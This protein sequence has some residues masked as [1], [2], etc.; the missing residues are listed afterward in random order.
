MNG[1]GVPLAVSNPLSATV[2]Q[3]GEQIAL[4]A[5]WLHEAHELLTQA[6]VPEVLPNETA[7]VAAR[8]RCLLQAYR[9]QGIDQLPPGEMVYPE[10]FTPMPFAADDDFL[11]AT[12]SRLTPAWFR[13]AGAWLNDMALAA[14]CRGLDAV[15][16]LLDQATALRRRFI[17]RR[18][19]HP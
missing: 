10:G 6:G 13:T 5:V 14:A 18:R 17:R 4:M 19:T 9:H 3:Q 16:W 11:P 1:D 8:I 2:K 15:E 12:S 7:T